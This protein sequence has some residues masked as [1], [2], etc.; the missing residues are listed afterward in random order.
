MGFIGA[1]FGFPFSL[2]LSIPGGLFEV[3][4]G[5]W[6]LTKGFQTVKDD[7]GERVPAAA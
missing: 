3:V 7:E 1:L 5:V 2:I 6:L 4:L